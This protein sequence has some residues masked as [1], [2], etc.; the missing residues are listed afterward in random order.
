MASSKV[1]KLADLE[2]GEQVFIRWAH[3]DGKQYWKWAE[4]SGAGK[5]SIVVRTKKGSMLMVDNVKSI[6]RDINQTGDIYER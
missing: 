4:V 5:K 2:K 1:E 6:M 3:P